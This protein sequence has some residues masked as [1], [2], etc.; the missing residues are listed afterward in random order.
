LRYM[1]Q[2]SFHIGCFGRAK[3]YHKPGMFL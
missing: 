1:L 2:Q 3:V